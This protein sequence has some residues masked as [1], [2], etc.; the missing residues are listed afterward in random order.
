MSMDV[1]TIGLPVCLG[2]LVGFL[3]GY[4]W[5]DYKQGK[6]EAKEEGIIK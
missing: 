3:A 5:C 1:I 4:G 6:K 2:Y